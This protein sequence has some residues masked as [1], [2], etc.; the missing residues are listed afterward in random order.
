[1]NIRELKHDIV[2]LD[3]PYKE[4]RLVYWMY[5]SVEHCY[6]FCTNFSFALGRAIPESI[7][8]LLRGSACGRR[9]L[10]LISLRLC[11]ERSSESGV[12][13]RGGWYQRMAKLGNGWN[14][15]GGGEAGT[16]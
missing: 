1:M 16:G 6:V 2:I 3:V 15:W 14:E 7:R 12:G 9:S 4:R 8:D 10:M 11:K 5:G 13:W